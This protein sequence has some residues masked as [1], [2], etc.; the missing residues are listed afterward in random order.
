M[1]TITSAQ[2]PN[3][4]LAIFRINQIRTPEDLDSKTKVEQFKQIAALSS[5]SE[6][7]AY[8]SNIRGRAGLKLLNPVQ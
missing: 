6:I 8:F 4:G 2:I 3:V 5:Q 7:A 1:P